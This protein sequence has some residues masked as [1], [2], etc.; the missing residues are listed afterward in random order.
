MDPPRPSLRPLPFPLS[1]GAKSSS[2]ANYKSASTHSVL[3]CSTATSRPKHTTAVPESH[4]TPWTLPPARQRSRVTPAAAVS[5]PRAEGASIGLASSTSSPADPT[6]T[7]TPPCAAPRATITAPAEDSYTRLQRHKQKLRQKRQTVTIHTSMLFDPQKEKFVADVTI[8][9]NV[10]TGKIARVIQHDADTEV[11]TKAGDVDLRGKFVMP[12]F[13]DSHT[14]VFLHS[15]RERPASV[16][17]ASEGIVERTIRASNHVRAALFAG[18][19]SLRDLSTEG[20]QSFDTDLRNC[21][22]RGLTPGPRLFVATSP[23]TSPIADHFHGDLASHVMMDPSDGVAA[24]VEAVRKR[25]AAGADVIKVYA[26][27]SSRL[28]SGSRYAGTSEDEP[29]RAVPAFTYAELRALVTEARIN[30]LPVAA[31]ATSAEAALMAVEAGASTLERGPIDADDELFHAMRERG[32]IYVPTLAALE[33][34]VPEAMQSM[35]RSVRLAYDIGVTIAA[36]SDSGVFAHGQGAR[37]LELLLDAGVPVAAVLCAATINGYRA[38]GGGWA[39]GVGAGS[40][41]SYASGSGNGSNGSMTGVGSASVQFGWLGEGC[42]ADIVA[43]NADPRTDPRAFRSVDFVMKEGQIWKLEGAR[44][45]LVFGPAELGFP[46]QD[47]AEAGWEVVE[48][49]PWRD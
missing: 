26:D 16:Q 5:R 39:R 23:L 45:P 37:E 14:H 42:M 21:I 8:E 44:T 31:H 7:T 25:A 15:Y 20:M 30:N 6:L 36:G 11:V 47:E 34:L 27:S 10:N 35:Q 9:V 40:G 4:S 33:A 18:Y 24:V 2:R 38:C 17:I 13:V 49:P 22:N 46:G 32:C 12:G 29:A 48:K 41:N 43:L 3:T 28:Y 19:T 1:G